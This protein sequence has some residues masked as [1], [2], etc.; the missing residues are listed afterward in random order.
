MLHYVTG[1][2]ISQSSPLLVA[3]ISAC[4]IHKKGFKQALLFAYLFVNSLWTAFGCLFIWLSMDFVIK[5]I[6]SRESIMFENSSWTFVNCSRTTVFQ[7]LS[8]KK[9]QKFQNIVYISTPLYTEQPNAIPQCFQNCLLWASMATMILPK[10]VC[11]VVS[12]SLWRYATTL[13]FVSS[14]YL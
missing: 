13:L 11:F 10:M 7:D 14:Y 2:V 5:I 12:L 8:L 4:S 6:C 9:I 3:V 1:K